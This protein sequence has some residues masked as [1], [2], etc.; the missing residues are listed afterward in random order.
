MSARVARLS[1]APT[2]S[3]N[4]QNAE[5]ILGRRRSRC[6][7]RTPEQLRGAAGHLF[8]R[9]LE[10]DPT[11]AK[12]LFY[13]AFAA[14]GRG[15]TPVARERFDAHAGARSAAADSRH[16]RKAASRAL[17]RR[18]AGGAERRCGVTAREGRG[19]RDA[20][21]FARRPRCRR[22]HCCSWRRAIRK[23][24]GP[25]FAVK[26]LPARFPVDVELTAA[27]AMLRVAA[28]RRRASSSRWSRAW[29]SGGTPTATSG[30][31]FGQVS[32]HVG[33]DGRLN[34]VIDRLAP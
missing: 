34:I 8:E 28:H 5:A 7:R 2:G 16:H 10:L 15:E 1:S 24:P 27:D 31:P 12:A 6:S 11:I 22:M 21:A 4:G 19:A 30:D 25:P 23:S 17:D 20:R 9:A 13:S 33:K 26:R 32:Y 18:G 14:L 29:R 3:P